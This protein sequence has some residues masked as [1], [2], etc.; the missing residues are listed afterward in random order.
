MTQLSFPMRVMLNDGEKPLC[1]DDLDHGSR[2]VK[3]QVGFTEEVG[4]C[5]FRS[6]GGSEGAVAAV[7]VPDF[8][9]VF[10]GL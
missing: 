5:G 1:T 6:D 8:G 3:A 10:V 7:W 2:G 4:P 9:F